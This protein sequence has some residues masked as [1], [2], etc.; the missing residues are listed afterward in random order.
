MKSISYHTTNSNLP[1][2]ELSFT[3]YQMKSISYRY[4]LSNSNQPV[5]EPYLTSYQVKTHKINLQSTRY[6]RRDIIYSNF[7]ERK[8]RSTISLTLLV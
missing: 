6:L 1:V 4:H 5:I 2:I 8:E 7:R 3:S